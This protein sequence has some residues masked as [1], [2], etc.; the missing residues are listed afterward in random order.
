M[1]KIYFSL[2]LIACTLQI[3]NAQLSLTKAFNEPVIGDVF[4][5]H[6]YDSTTA[7][8]KATGAG[9]NWNFTSLTL[10]AFNET[11]TYTTTASTPSAAIF[12]GAT[13][14]EDKGTGQYTHYKSTPT[15]FEFQ[16]VQFP[17]AVVNFSNTGIFATWPVNFGYVGNDTFGG[18]TT[19]GT[20]TCSMNGSIN[21]SGVGTGT[22]VMPGGGLI[23]TNCL[24]VLNNITFTLTQGTSTT[25]QVQKEYSYYHSSNKFPVINIRY[26]TS[27]SGTV[28]T[29]QFTCF[30]NN[31]IV[32]GLTT[33]E[34]NNNLLVFPN[35]ASEIINVSLSNNS[36]DNV[37][38]TLTNV[39]GKVVKNENLGN[40]NLIHSNLN[41]NE[42]PKGIYFMNVYIGQTSS[43]KKIVIE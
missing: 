14:S 36:N 34:I 20:V 15:T 9:Q 2:L 37:S 8:P 4:I 5:K 41:V 40:K 13:I 21:L 25:T 19:T 30:V 17:G 32:A 24:Q 7:V 22:V 11:S 35:P 26:Q 29:N 42:L 6:Q 12:P 31:A 38:V 23:L 10:N 28:T 39:I 1:K 16:G 33:H 3:S 27:T 18:S 43:V